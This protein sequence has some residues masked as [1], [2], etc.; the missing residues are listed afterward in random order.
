MT[1]SLRRLRI[2]GAAAVALAIAGSPAPSAAQHAV[3]RATDGRPDAT[4]DL[5]TSEGVTLVR[6]QWRY[7]DATLVAATFNA[8]GPDRKPSGAPVKTLDQ[9]LKVGTPAFDAAAWQTIDAPAL[10]DRRGRGRVSFAWYRIDVTIPERI[11]SFATAGS[12]AVFEI[13]VDDYAEIW[14]DGQLPRVLGQS[15]GALVKGW[16]APNRVILTRNAQPGQTIRLAVFAA[17]A[18]LSDP[19]PNYIWVRSAALDFYAAPA[20]PQGTPVRVVKADP[21]LDAIVPAD[22]RIEKLADGFLFTEGPVW[23]PEGYLLFSDPDANTIYR[24]SDDDGLSVFRTKSG[25]TGANIGDYKQPGSNGLAVDP[26]GRLTINEHGNRRVTRLEKN[27][28]L[29]V[30]ADRFEGRRLNSPNDLVYA[31]NGSLY[32]TDPPFGLPKVFD[33]PAKETPFSGVYRWSN[34]TI[35]LITRELTG[36]NGIALSPDETYLYVGNWDDNKK[37]VMRYALDAHGRASGGDVFA[38]L[39]SAPGDDA[40]DG[41]KVDRA[42]N[43]YVSGP[44]GLWIFSP[45]GRHLGTIDAPE[46]VHNFAWGGADGR[47]LYLA[48]RSGL[49]RMRMAIAGTPSRITNTQ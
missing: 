31:S 6:G 37:V 21:A 23:S 7:A 8:A 43:V 3:R 14:V 5:R 40:I 32:F 38:D 28:V 33:D 10:E 36:P 1:R 46:H 47:T 26:E 16:N 35:E 44:G 49:Y 27:G 42:G 20:A 30:L 2:A 34:G 39:T 45:S 15:G 25:Y 48:A 29:T 13:V 18:P 12:T 19:P 17:N 22:A 9:G 41:V 11:G 4:I 24:W